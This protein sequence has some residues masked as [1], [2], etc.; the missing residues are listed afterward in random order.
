MLSPD[1]RRF[2]QQ[3]AL[4]Q[5]LAAAVEA[6]D[7]WHVTIHAVGVFPGLYD[8]LLL[9]QLGITPESWLDS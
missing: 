8:Y 4:D 9:K 5:L 3:A 1:E 2:V 6:F 7:R